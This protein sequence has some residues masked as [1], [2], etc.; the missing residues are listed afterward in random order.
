M[1]YHKKT[2]NSGGYSLCYFDMSVIGLLTY[3]VAN[4][5]DIKIERA[6]KPKNAGMFHRNDS[7]RNDKL[8]LLNPGGN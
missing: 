5:Y 3:L 7:F 4:K 1:A 8:G 2:S 6:F